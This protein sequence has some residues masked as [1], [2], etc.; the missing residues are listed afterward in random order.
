MFL[1]NSLLNHVF[2]VTSTPTGGLV[3]I[4]MREKYLQEVAEYRGRLE[5]RMKVI[6]ERGLWRALERTIIPR[7]SFDNNGVIFVFEVTKEEE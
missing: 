6:E 5:P 3:V 4:V 1:E 2:L 7:Y